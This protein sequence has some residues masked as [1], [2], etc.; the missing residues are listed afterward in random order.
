M[1][2]QCLA[3]DANFI[4][5]VDKS[6][7]LYVL[8]FDAPTSV[9]ENGTSMIPKEW[10]LEQNHPNPF[11][12]LTQIGYELPKSARVVIKIFNVRGQEIRTLF[13]TFQ[14]AGRKSTVWDGLDSRGQ[15]VSSG[16]YFYRIEAGDFTAFK[17]MILVL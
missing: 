7:G 8:R 3:L 15:K 17:K 5:L 14:T 4:Y 11:N 10:V 16:L 2:P 12:P 1:N 6:D 9:E 13:D